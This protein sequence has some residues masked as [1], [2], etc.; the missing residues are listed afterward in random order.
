M[1]SFSWQGGRLSHLVRAKG[2][3]QRTDF[4][5][6]SP[7]TG[8]WC[9]QRKRSQAKRKT[10]RADPIGRLLQGEGGSFTC[11]QSSIEKGGEKK[12]GG[13]LILLNG[14]EGKINSKR[15]RGGGEG[16]NAMSI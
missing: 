2:E 8:P 14:G 1:K 3:G 15:T 12:K 9:D 11:Y 5:T 13:I 16:E 10:R 6:W 4:R 7:T